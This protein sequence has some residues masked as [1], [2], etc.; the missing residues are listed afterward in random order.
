MDTTQLNRYE[1]A[2]LVCL[3]SSRI[4]EQNV[5]C[6]PFIIGFVGKEN[7]KYDHQWRIHC[8]WHKKNK[9]LSHSHK[10]P[11]KNGEYTQIKF[12]NSA[13]PVHGLK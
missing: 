6:C 3:N 2:K 11:D 5:C 1:A 12:I 4:N 13:R 10:V 8:V 9:I 7:V